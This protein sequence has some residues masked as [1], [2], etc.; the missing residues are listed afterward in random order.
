[1][2]EHVL[3]KKKLLS[4]TDHAPKRTTHVELVALIESIRSPG[5][6]LTS[7]QATVRITFVYYLK[8]G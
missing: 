7:D 1:M 6:I 3:N 8:I 4:G 2:C 5:T